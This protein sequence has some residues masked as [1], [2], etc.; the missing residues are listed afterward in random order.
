MLGK[1]LCKVGIL[2]KSRTDLKGDVAHDLK[3]GWVTLEIKMQNRL[4]PSDGRGQEADNYAF[5]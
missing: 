4:S 2:R 1:I 3:P 5:C